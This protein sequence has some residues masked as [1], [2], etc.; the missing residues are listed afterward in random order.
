[1]S[2]NIAALLK[3]EPSRTDELSKRAVDAENTVRQ[4]VLNTYVTWWS[5]RFAAQA[6]AET[7]ALTTATFTAV[8]ARVKVGAAT[9][10]DLISAR[11]RVTSA[12]NRLRDFNAAVVTTRAELARLC[13]ISAERLQAILSGAE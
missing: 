1:M 5:A 6:A 7:V 12:I 4:N 9:A 13:N 2:I 10:T 8:A 3:T 11:E